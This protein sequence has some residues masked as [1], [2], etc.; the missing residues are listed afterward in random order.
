MSDYRKKRLNEKDDPSA[1]EAAT[2]WAERM[3]GGSKDKEQEE[4]EDDKPKK[5]KNLWEKLGRK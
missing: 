5:F 1:S 4:P 3:L 2:S